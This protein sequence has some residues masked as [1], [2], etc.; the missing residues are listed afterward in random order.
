MNVA[1]SLA[2]TNLH[3]INVRNAT[4]ETVID[5]IYAPPSEQRPIGILAEPKT[6]DI[7]LA[8]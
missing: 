1:C 3:A 8:R 7:V 5:T 4:R 2:N 6:G